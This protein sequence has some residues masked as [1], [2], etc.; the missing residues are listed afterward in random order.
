M[1]VDSNVLTAVETPVDHDTS[2]PLPGPERSAAEI[3]KH[4]EHVLGK[5][6][7]LQVQIEELRYTLEWLKTLHQKAVHKELGATFGME[8]V[9]VDGDVKFEKK[10]DNAGD[11]AGA[12]VSCDGSLE[13]EAET[14]ESHRGGRG[15]GR[16]GLGRGRP[17]R[18]RPTKAG[19]KAPSNFCQA[20]WNQ[21]RGL[22]SAA[23]HSKGL[24]G[25]ACCNAKGPMRQMWL[26]M[27]DLPLESFT[28][29][30]ASCSNAGA[31]A[32]CGR[33]RQQCCRQWRVGQQ[34]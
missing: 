16:N 26:E 8:G 20:C 29:N 6:A 11:D 28:G 7:R 17:G 15:R 5:R 4:I 33:T 23:R 21:K 10:E 18:P 24:D 19:A 2:L 9:E 30:G 1:S 31:R 34:R 14:G 13:P 27:K 32:I 3:R 22:Y 25:T 12:H